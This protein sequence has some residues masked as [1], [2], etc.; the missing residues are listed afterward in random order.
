MSEAPLVLAG[1]VLAHLLADFVFQTDAIAVG[2][3]G[4]GPR[5]WRWLGVHVGVVALTNLPV[6]VVFGVRGLAFVVM[7]VLTHLAIDRTKIV[8]TRRTASP[9][10]E[11]VAEGGDPAEGPPLDRAWSPRPAGLFVIDQLAHLGVL[12]VLWVVFLTGE[13]PTS[14]W[15]DLSSRLSRVASPH[16]V[17]RF[18]L[19]LVVI[20]NLAIVNVRAAALFVA[21]LVQAPARHDEGAAAAGAEVS[22]AK[23]GATIGVLERLIVCALVLVGEFGAIGLVITAKTIARFKQLEDRQFAEY[24][25]LGTLASVSVA[26]LTGLLALVALSG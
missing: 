22:P 4:D 24:Y 7:T 1:L 16:D 20:A 2:K 5:A 21:T 10:R 12:L 14:T 15:S 17:Y 9:V 25:L 19:G 26:I 23:V 18:T 13:G 3:F 11:A 8:L 6:V